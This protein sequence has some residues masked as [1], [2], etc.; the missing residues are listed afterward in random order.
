LNQQKVIKKTILGLI[1]SSSA[2]A[3]YL[4]N[5]STPEMPEDG[6]FI[7]ADCWLG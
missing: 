3:L 6:A 5:P 4:G 2:H 1:I 7:N